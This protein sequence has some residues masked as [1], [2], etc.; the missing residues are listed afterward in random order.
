MLKESKLPEFVALSNYEF[1]RRTADAYYHLWR[2]TGNAAD[3]RKADAT[4]SA[5]ID[6]FSQ[7]MVYFQTLTFWQPMSPGNRLIYNDGGFLSL[8]ASIQRQSR[9]PHAAR[10]PTWSA[11]V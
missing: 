8:L 1:Y 4:I 5:A 7:H 6:R 9:R 2:A 10:L 11:A 3:R